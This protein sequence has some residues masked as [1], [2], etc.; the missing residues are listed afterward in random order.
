MK[1]PCEF[2]EVKNVNGVVV[3]YRCCFYSV[4]SYSDRS[5]CPIS[6][7]PFNT[8]SDALDNALLALE[9]GV[10]AE[11][12]AHRIFASPHLFPEL[13]HKIKEYVSCSNYD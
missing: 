10:F 7:T 1:V 3:G 2:K 11:V 8:Q 13:Y 5:D 4:I 6:I 9:C 12:Q